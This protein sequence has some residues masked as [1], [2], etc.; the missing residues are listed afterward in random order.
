MIDLFVCAI[1]VY[2]A[3]QLR[4]NFV[5]PEQYLKSL[6]LFVPAIVAVRAL[7][8]LIFR[9][10]SGIIQHTSTEDAQRIFI[11]IASGSLL[12]ELSNIISFQISDKY[13]IPHS[14]IIIDSLLSIFLMTGIRLIFKKLY[15]EIK[16]SNI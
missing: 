8:F 9:T 14:V 4:F 3:Y 2:F 16:K 7:S 12:V 1:S 5:I 11:A 10:F 6:I 15:F 13:L